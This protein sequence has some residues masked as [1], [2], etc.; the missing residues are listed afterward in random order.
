MIFCNQLIQLNSSFLPVRIGSSGRMSLTF[1]AYQYSAMIKK[2]NMAKCFFTAIDAKKI[3]TFLIFNFSFFIPLFAQETETPSTSTEQQIEN[4]TEN[5]EDA[6]IE[7]DSYVLQMQQYLQHPINL[8]TADEAELKELQINPVQIKSLINYRLFFGSLI[9]IYELQAVPFWNVDAIQKIRPYVTVS[10]NVVI[11]NS[12]GNRL[13]NGEHTLLARVSQVV[14]KSKGYL[15]DPNSSNNYYQ[16]APQRLLLRYRY[17]YKN[18]L[19]YGFVGEKDAGEQ[20]F[21]GTQKQGFD[22]YSAHFFARNIGIIKSLAIGDY[23]VNM[24]QGLTQWQSL[25]FKKSPDVTNVKRQAAVLRPY[26]SAGEYNFHRGIGITLGQ[27]K[28]Q[29]TLFGSY[30]KIDANFVSDT[31]QTADDF[32]SSLQISGLHR[33]KSETDDKNIQRQL[34]FGGNLSYQYKRLHVGVNGIQYQFKLPISKQDEPYNLYALSGKSFGNYSID[35]NY[36]YKNMHLFG[37]AATTQGGY[38]AFV[39]GLLISTSSIVDMSVVY[40]NISPQYQS[41]YASAFTENT[42]PTNEKGFYTGISIKPSIAWRVDAYVDFYQFPWLKYRVDAPTRGSDYLVQITYKPNKQV[43][44][45]SRYRTESKSINYNPEEF[46]LSPVIPKP[47]QSWRNQISYKINT[48]I[49]LR[50]RTEL[51]WFDK[52]G[53]QPEE[54]FLTYFDCLIKPQLKKYAGSVRVLYFETGSYNSR[55]YAYENDVLYS[56]SIPV[57]YDKGFRYYINFNYDLS[58]KLTLWARWAQT[59]YKDKNTIGSSLDEIQGNTRSDFKFQAVYRF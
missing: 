48:A 57:F 8:N 58:K 56:F 55:L 20:I 35:Y 46:T 5:T 24:G 41:L 6:E 28:W 10:N 47:R 12:I 7:D 39:N 3:L 45:Y 27:N 40:R 9:N 18:L 14:E 31:S 38:K 36:T 2:K 13:K 32:I 23:T 17:T 25:A 33:T 16:G 50:N 29:V 54:G 21:K 34:A 43:E 49:T 52:K 42:F 19:Q 30:K 59:I 15:I 26:N 1:T 11:L 22:F 44:I 4:L 53:D 51:L 37:E